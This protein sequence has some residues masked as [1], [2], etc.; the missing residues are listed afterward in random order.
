MFNLLADNFAFV[1]DVC[2]RSQKKTEKIW[3]GRKIDIVRK[4]RKSEIMSKKRYYS[5]CDKCVTI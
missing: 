1:S 4:K 3:K 5:D 2:S